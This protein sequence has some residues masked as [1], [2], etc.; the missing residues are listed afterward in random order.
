LFTSGLGTG[1]PIGEL[2]ALARVLSMRLA[3]AGF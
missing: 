1:I 3:N 2:R